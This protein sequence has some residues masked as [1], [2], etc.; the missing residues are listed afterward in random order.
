MLPPAWSPVAESSTPVD[1]STS[2]PR[3]SNGVITAIAMTNMV[4]IAA[5]TAQPCR[6]EP[7]IR[8]KVYVSAK[9]STTSQK[10]SR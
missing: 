8:P 4:I 6:R 1:W 10:S 7:T 2:E 3:C 5:N 9:A